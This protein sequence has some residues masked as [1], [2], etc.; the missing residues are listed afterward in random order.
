MS[1]LQISGTRTVWV[2]YTNSD[3][4]EGRGY[5]VPH[6]VCA[7]EA[8]ARRLGKGKSVMG[9]DCQV[10]AVTAVRIGG[11]PWLVPGAI[12]PASESDKRMQVSLDA[13]RTVVERAKAAGLSDEEIQL[14]RSTP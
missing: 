2:A 3:L 9:S 11:G 5:Q 13:R 10:E 4:T 7:M 1:E 8:T 6:A 14:L 12:E